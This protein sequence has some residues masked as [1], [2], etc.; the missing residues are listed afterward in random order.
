MLGEN[1]YSSYEVDGV[2]KS[3]CKL[4]RIPGFEFQS[5]EVSPV[6]SFEQEIAQAYELSDQLKYC[7]DELYSKL[8][9]GSTVQLEPIRSLLLSCVSSIERNVFSWLFLCQVK[10]PHSYLVEHAFRTAV[11]AMALGTRLR[12]SAGELAE[13]GL[14][15]MVSD[16]GKIMIPNSI[17]E[18]E[19]ALNSAEYAVIQVHPLEGR[20]ILLSQTD[21]SPELIEV[22]ISHH[23]QIDGT[24]YPTKLFGESIPYFARIVAIADAYDAMTSERSYAPARSITDA[25]AILSFCRDRQFDASMVE[26]FLNMVGAFPSGTEIRLSEGGSAVVLE[27]L[28]GKKAELKVISTQDPS[29]LHVDVVTTDARQSDKRYIATHEPSVPNNMT[30]QELRDLLLRQNTA[31]VADIQSN[32]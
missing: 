17:L 7:I 26:A 22:V 8:R 14:A 18:K 4:N 21:A 13:L 28:A 16:V 11:L 23:E 3:S 25:Q 5:L 6:R 19:G 9:A 27:P 15:A 20:K 32:K 2:S 31:V 29:G 24:G 10:N 12:L 1:N 30:Q